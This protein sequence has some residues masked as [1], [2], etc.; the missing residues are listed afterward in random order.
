[1]LEPYFQINHVKKIQ[2]GLG[3]GLSIVKKA[4]DSLAGEMAI[5]SDSTL[6]VGTRIQIK[7]PLHQLQT[8]ETVSTV[9][10]S[11]R[12]CL[13]PY[14]TLPTDSAFD[15]TKPTVLIVEDNFEMVNY[16]KLK[17]GTGIQLTDCI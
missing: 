16:L 4:V 7:L 6:F 8:G 2:P 12:K 11:I 1:V 15:N 9:V 3:L 10:T 17:L 14:K 13:R 5:D